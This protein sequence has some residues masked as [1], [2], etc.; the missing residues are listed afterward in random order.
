MAKKKDDIR[1]YCTAGEAATILS[2]KLS[3]V[4]RPDYISKMAKAKKRTIRR[5]QMGNRS[6]YHRE[7]IAACTVRPLE[8]API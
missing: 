3:R 7:D 4:I 2:E 8:H 5:V 1:D 6:L